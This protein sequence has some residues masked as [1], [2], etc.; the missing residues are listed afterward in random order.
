[1]KPRA[2]NKKPAEHVVN[3]PNVARHQMAVRVVGTSNLIVH[4]FAQKAITEMLCKQRGI[5]FERVK[6][7]PEADYHDS[8]YL[9]AEGVD[10]VPV[11][12]L[13]KAMTESVTLSDGMSKKQ[14][15]A[16]FMILGEYAPLTFREMR[17]RTD[18][19]RLSGIGR[20][21][22]IRFRAEYLDWSADIVI[23]FNP[24]HATPDQVLYMLR[25]AGTSI[26]ICEWRVQKGGQFGTFR[27][28]PLADTDVPKIIEACRVPPAATILPDWLLSGDMSK[29]ELSPPEKDGLLDEPEEPV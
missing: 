19:V 27:A 13:K 28:E 4:R 3:L 22:D 9:N 20:T 24:Q 6:K 2:K 14:A 15:M 7:N 8:R 12:T 25:E 5:P 10:C 23:D 18:M 21:P 11:M 26:G 29:V 1:M 16:S 17:M